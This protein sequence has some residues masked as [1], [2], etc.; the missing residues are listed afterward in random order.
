MRNLKDIFERNRQWAGEINRDQP[1]F[2]NRLAEKQK[3]AYLWIGCSDSRVPATTLCGFDPGDVFVHR[4]VAN[5]VAHTD[6]NCLSVIQY[7]VEV[8]EVKHIIVCGHYGCGGVKAAMDNLELGLIDNWLRNIQD[9]INQYRVRLDSV[10]DPIRRFEALCELNVLVQ[11]LNVSRTT[12][13]GRA[14]TNGG[15]LSVHGWIYGIDDGC[16]V[17][18]D[19]CVTGIGELE[20]VENIS[21]KGIFSRTRIRKK[22]QEKM[23]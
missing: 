12:V 19:I 3:P 11:V 8:L 17:D 21:L 7:A 15:E 14:W 23:C 2:F 16:L 18:L 20:Q 5:I 10:V 13:V 9:I 22:P 4:N 6:F 1:D